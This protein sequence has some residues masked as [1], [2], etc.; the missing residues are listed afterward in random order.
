MASF[1]H[2][3][4]LCGGWAVDAW[5]GRTTRSHL[6]VDIT[7]FHEHQLAAYEH[8]RSWNLAGHDPGTDSGGD[9]W[10]GRELAFPAHVHGRPPG[11]RNRR[12]LA[13]WVNPPHTTPPDGP[14]LEIVFNLRAGDDLVLSR[15]PPLGV[16]WADAA[17]ESR[18]DVPT[19]VPEL[20]L[21][22]KLTSGYDP[23]LR[24]MPR[25]KDARDVDAL[26]PRLGSGQRAW[27][28]DAIA[29]VHPDHGWL[30][31]LEP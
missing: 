29:T 24:A 1:P 6:D 23:I 25:K 31:L 26:A 20:L 3:W 28:R 10:D 9:G 11:A 22:W 13:Q 19:I 17:R 7:V 21:Y 30:G 14:N 8:F 16:A 12:L 5:L 2:P 27:L 15:T 18:W 4:A